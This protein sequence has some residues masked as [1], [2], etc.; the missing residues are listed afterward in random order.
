M[1]EFV[2]KVL[3]AIAKETIGHYLPELSNAQVLLSDL[4]SFQLR[5]VYPKFTEAGDL[6]SLNIS[7]RVGPFPD[8]NIVGKEPPQSIYHNG[9]YSLDA[10][11]NCA[12]NVNIVP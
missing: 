3:R 11:K 6:D 9:V 10:V 5:L 7:V 2:R 12:I 8:S 1:H 4:T